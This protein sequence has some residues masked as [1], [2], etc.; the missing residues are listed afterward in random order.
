LSSNRHSSREQPNPD[1]DMTK[2][3]FRSG[4]LAV[5]HKRFF[6]SF[7][8]YY[9]FIKLFC[10]CVS[11]EGFVRTQQPALDPP[12]NTKFIARQLQHTQQRSGHVDYCR[13]S[14]RDTRP[15]LTA[16][17]NAD[18]NVGRQCRPSTLDLVMLAPGRETSITELQ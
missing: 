4:A 11:W 17:N 6:M 18:S 14:A 12:L 9:H 2:R 13:P 1:Y 10:G 8:V 16:D 15:R 5:A 7:I 3:S